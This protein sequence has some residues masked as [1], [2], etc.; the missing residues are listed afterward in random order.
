MSGMKAA[1]RLAYREFR[2]LLRPV[3]NWFGP[4]FGNGYSL[5][6]RSILIQ[7]TY[8][9]NL[10]CSFCGQ[11]GET[12]IFK[13]L[14]GSE[15]REMLPLAVLKRVID[16]LPLI[17]SAADLWGGETLQYP[18]IIPLVRYIK[19][20]ERT[21]SLV[22]NGTYLARHARGDRKSTRLNSSH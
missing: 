13:K 20:S 18:D 14:P 16:E 10:R 19:E 2:R 3:Q 9:C 6:P 12:G 5:G 8:R 1:K 21:C 17:C 7:L 11:W 4:R 15:I 22:T